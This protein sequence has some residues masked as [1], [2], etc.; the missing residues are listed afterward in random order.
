[1]RQTKRSAAHPQPGQRR[2]PDRHLLR[3]SSVLL[4]GDLRSRDCSDIGPRL[5]FDM[6]LLADRLRVESS[7]VSSDLQL[8]QAVSLGFRRP[9]ARRRTLL[10]TCRSDRRDRLAGPSGDRASGDIRGGRSR[11]YSRIGYRRLDIPGFSI[12]SIEKFCG[13]GRCP[14][15][16]KYRTKLRAQSARTPAASGVFAIAPSI[17]AS[18]WS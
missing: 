11:A 8:T 16:Q 10:R 2:E 14:Q 9:H 1:M 12:F 13:V 18:I 17:K 4:C 6:G 7:S 5:I 3:P 15:S